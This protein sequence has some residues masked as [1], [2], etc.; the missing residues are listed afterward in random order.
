ME[1][2]IIDLTGF[3]DKLERWSGPPFDQMIEKTTKQ[4]VSYVL[5]RV[6]KYPPPPAGSR[7]RRTGTLGRSISGK[8]KR[9]GSTWR[10]FVG[11]KV[12]YAP[13]VIDEQFQARVHQGRWYTLQAVVR[14]ARDGVLRLYRDA[15]KEF[16]GR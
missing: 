13:Y 12:V 1:L 4:A 10:G 9:L 3:F 5:Q 11:T 7:Y 2:R 6:P 16:F 15:L 14:G 8:V